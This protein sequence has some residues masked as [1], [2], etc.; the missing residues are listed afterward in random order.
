MF[1]K[2]TR[3]SDDIIVQEKDNNYY[4]FLNNNFEEI[5]VKEIYAIIGTDKKIK[6]NNGFQYELNKKYTSEENIFTFYWDIYQAFYDYIFN[7]ENRYFFVKIIPD[8]IRGDFSDRLYSSNI[9]IVKE[10]T[11]Y[12]EEF[13][14][15]G[16]VVIDE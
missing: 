4:R 6:T 7:N 15:Y 16:S 1:E 9:E 8:K 5:K 13:I 10:I 11:T 2:Y 12:Y 3:I 14:Y